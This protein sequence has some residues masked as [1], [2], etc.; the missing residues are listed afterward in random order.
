MV[1]PLVPLN[2][3]DEAW[4]EINAESPSFDHP[5]YEASESSKGYV[6]QNWLENPTIFPRALW[7]HYGNFGTRA[8]NH[9]EGWHRA[10]K[11][12]IK[13]PHVDTFKFIK[14]L[15]YQERKFQKDMLLISM[16][17]EPHDLAENTLSSMK[18]WRNSPLSSSPMRQL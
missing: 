5:A 6:I 18:S 4:L 16:G 9:L 17:E 15:K 8:T 1:L 10:L 3:L 11:E 7:N 14:H 13:T 2:R 12:A